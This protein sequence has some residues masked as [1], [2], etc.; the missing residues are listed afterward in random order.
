MSVD[1]SAG[2]VYGWKLTPARYNELPDDIK[3]EYGI[4]TDCYG[5][6]GS[7]FVG[8]KQY[9]ADVGEYDEVN[10]DE[11]CL[12]FEDF[13]KLI[14]AIPDIINKYPNPSLYLYCRVS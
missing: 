4:Q 7:Y 9:G 11:I 2:M 3:D 10:T 5:Y 1:Y 13:A 12:P 6:G 14:A 8:V